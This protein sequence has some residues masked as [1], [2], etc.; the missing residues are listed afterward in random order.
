METKTGE[1]INR[2]K[3]RGSAGKDGGLRQK[4]EVNALKSL[5]HKQPKS[6]NGTST[7]NNSDLNIF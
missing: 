7:K 2:K 1:G 6:P 4:N 3:S 5:P